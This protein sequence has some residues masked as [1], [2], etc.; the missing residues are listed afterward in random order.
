[1]IIILMSSVFSLSTPGPGLSFSFIDCIKS[2]L[3]L[4]YLFL[5]LLFLRPVLLLRAF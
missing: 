2:F 1:M 3:F 4:V 5:A